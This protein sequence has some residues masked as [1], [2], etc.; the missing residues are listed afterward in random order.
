MRRPPSLAYLEQ[1]RTAERLRTEFAAEFRV[2]PIKWSGHNL[3]R[4]LRLTGESPARVAEMRSILGALGMGDPRCSWIAAAGIFDHGEA[5]G[6]DRVPRYFVGHPYQ[7]GDEQRSL[8]ARLSRFNAL[9]VHIDDRPS[10]YGFGTHHV[11]VELAGRRRPWMEMP[12]TP[13]TRKAARL[14]RR[15]F[16]EEFGRPTFDL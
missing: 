10:Y 1:V 12:A 16:L 13:W 9:I 14:A 4:M 11:R 5:W 7:V 2:R 15:A 6:R 3:A 8:L